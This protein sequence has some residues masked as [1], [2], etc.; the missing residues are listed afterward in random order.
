MRNTRPPRPPP[1][2]SYGLSGAP[3]HPPHPPPFGHT[4]EAVAVFRARWAQHVK[5]ILSASGNLMR[6]TARPWRR[7][8]AW[9]CGRAWEKY[10]RTDPIV[11]LQQREAEA[12]LEL[13]EADRGLARELGVAPTFRGRNGEI[14]IRL[15]WES[16]WK[17]SQLGRLRFTYADGEQQYGPW[18]IDAPSAWESHWCGPSFST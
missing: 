16:H 13:W 1:W 17:D 12:N 4:S 6:F 11:L 18:S 8:R 7:F 10:F 14:V 5:A 9:R 2:F 15:D 3:S